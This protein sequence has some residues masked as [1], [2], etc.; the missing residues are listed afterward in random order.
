MPDSHRL[1]FHYVN[2]SERLK[3]PIIKGDESPASWPHA[4]RAAAEQLTAD[5]QATAMIASARM[6]NEELFLARRLAIALG[7]EL[8]DVLPR[9]QKGDGFLISDDGNPNTMG[10]KADRTRHRE[11]AG[12]CRRSRRRHD[13]VSSRARRRRP[14]MRDLRRSISR[15]SIRWWSQPYCLTEPLPTPRYFFRPRAGRRSEGR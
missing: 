15:S 7:I 5:P 4:I 1:N 2:S 11:V 6:T 8:F 12:N 14:G 9:P 13:Q 10:A 3:E